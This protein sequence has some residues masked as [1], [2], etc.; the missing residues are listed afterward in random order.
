MKWS[1]STLS[2]E[3]KKETVLHA[4]VTLDYG[5]VVGEYL[6]SKTLTQLVDK[7][8]ELWIEEYGYELIER[9]S[10]EVVEQA[11]KKAVAERILKP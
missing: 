10:P 5:K 7:A 1:F 11:I 8:V 6:D 4:R 3:K 2:N 9:I